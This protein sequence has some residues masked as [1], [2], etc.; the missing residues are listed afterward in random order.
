MRTSLTLG[1]VGA[2]L[3][4][5]AAC[6]VDP[7]APT[8]VADLRLDRADDIVEVFVVLNGAPAAEAIPS[9][10]DVGHPTAVK[11]VRQRLAE[12]EA[13]HDALR[14]QLQ[15]Q[16]ARVIAELT[17]LGNAFHIRVAAKTADRFAKWPEVDH[18]E[19]VPLFKRTLHTGIPVVGAPSV[20]NGATPFHGDG[21]RL[22]IIDSGIDYLHAGFGAPGDPADYANNDST[23]V[24]PGSFPT[25]RVVAGWDLV[26]DGYNPENGAS[27]P[28]PDLDPL[29]CDG[30][31]SH[32]AGIAAGGGVLSDGTPFTGPYNQSFDPTAFRV[33]PGV[34]P[35]ADLYA[36]K[37]F[38]CNGGTQVFASAIELASDPDDDGD[39]SDRLDVI[40]ASLGSA[41]G[42]NSPF[43]AA[44]VRNYTELGG[45][46]VSAAG[47][48]GATFWAAGSAAVYPGALSVA[49]TV[50][51]LWITLD[52]QSPANVAGQYA[53]SE[54]QFTTSL[55]ISGA[56][57]GD[58]VQPQPAN[59]CQPFANAAEVAGQIALIDRGQCLF[60][61]KMEQAVAAGAAGAIIIND[62]FGGGIFPMAPSDPEDE[63]PIAGVMISAED[64]QILKAALAQGLSG[65][66]DP[67]V[68]EGDAAELVAGLSSRGPSIDGALFKPEIAAPGVT[69][70]SVDVGSGNNPTSKNG[71]SMATPFVAGAA[72]LV[73]QAH[74]SWSPADVKAGLMATA[75]T[76]SNEFGVEYPLTMQGAGR[77]DV[78]EAV[79]RNVTAMASR[80]DGA[81]ALSFGA[82]VTDKPWS[83]SQEVLVH[84][85]GSE[86]VTYSVG[87]QQVLPLPGIE[88]SVSPSNITVAPGA[89]ETVTFT[90]DVSP[91][92]LGAP[93][94]DD[95]TPST[96][97]DLPRHWLDEAEGYLVFTDQEGG[98]SLRLPFHAAVR[99]AGNRVA[100]A[101]VGCSDGASVTSVILP[102]AGESAHPNPVTSV[103]ELGAELEEDP[104]SADD[105]N[106][107]MADLRAV[108]VATDSATA[109]PADISVFFGIAVTG[110][111]TSPA[112]PPISLV[113]VLIDVDGDDAEDR[114]L[115]VEPLGAEPPYAD[116]LASTTYIVEGG[117]GF[118]GFY[119]GCEQT[120]SKRFINMVPADVVTSYPYLNSVIVLGAFARDLGLPS[121]TTSF[122]YKA[123]SSGVAGP[124]DESPWL[125]F[126]YATPAIDAAPFAPQEGRP[127][128]TGEDP[129]ELRLGAADADGNVGSA[130]LLHHTNARGARFEVVPLSG[131]SEVPTAFRHDFPETASASALLTKRIYVD[132]PGEHPLQAA[133]LS[134]SITGG[135]LRLAAPEKGSCAKGETID[136]DL[137]DIPAFSTVVVTLQIQPDS[138]ASSLQLDF[139][140]ESASG[141]ATAESLAVSLSDQAPTAPPGL[142]VGGGCGC[143]VV[144]SRRTSDHAGWLLSLLGL[145]ICTRRRQTRLAASRRR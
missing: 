4:S 144:S 2:A 130:L 59:G 90:L 1:A 106:I 96:Q 115:V 105:P 40:N 51:S 110:E 85:H 13:Q 74:P 38:G 53:A 91:S 33:A 34:A 32:V 81:V 15:A 25:T 45:L 46:L 78:A 127:I 112:A 52:V 10:M 123:V 50:D 48:D 98:Q 117:C 19:P 94:P 72:S 86:P 41:F 143:E 131:L 97:F 128:F 68:F 137:G 80:D 67:V 12:L 62:D 21:V 3:L 101:P 92:D 17:R 126:D 23:T 73:R 76:L 55:A 58:L 54:G 14:P 83:D 7:P 65:T 124:V 22:G 108:G 39:M 136:C 102:L 95:A 61:D 87:S 111:W 24:E 145:G 120:E 36:I 134:G 141:C 71:T 37:V 44:V 8:R 114:A 122:R 89:T 100:S 84:N 104:S 125:D 69:V 135:S 121:D 113:N 20:W 118:F 66:L 42:S 63:S 16:G 35:K 11:H 77:L 57:G 56:L 103:F 129:I 93:S 26:G 6:A 75:D 27:T 109:E 18:I 9:G 140:G 30:H 28:F 60:V 82:V 139:E 70:N 116:V 88:T 31:G 79:A 99:A 29:D 5:T 107:A 119:G 49:A 47:N 64:G 43:T 142:D 133:R 132:N 138:D